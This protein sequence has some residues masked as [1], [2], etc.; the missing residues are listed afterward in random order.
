LEA[1]SDRKPEPGTRW[2]AN[3][4]R[5]DRAHRAFLASNPV[6]NGSFHTHDRFGWLEFAR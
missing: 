2:R 3:F 1:L 5:I 6:L 4:Y